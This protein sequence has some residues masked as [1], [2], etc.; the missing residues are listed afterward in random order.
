M[1]TEVTKCERVVKL[2][3]DTVTGCDPIPNLF[4]RHGQVFDKLHK[5]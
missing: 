3:Q 2:K 5:F 1:E 4:Q